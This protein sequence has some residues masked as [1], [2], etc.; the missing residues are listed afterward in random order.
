MDGDPNCAECQRLTWAY[1]AAIG[2]S[3]ATFARLLRSVTSLTPKREIDA[4]NAAAHDWESNQNRRE[5]IAARM[6]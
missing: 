1:A 3:S 5:W 2:T 6:T 4:H